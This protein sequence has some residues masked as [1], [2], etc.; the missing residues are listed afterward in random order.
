MTR[1]LQLGS[2]ILVE[3][4]GW[5]RVDQLVAKCFDTVIVKSPEGVRSGLISF[6]FTSDLE[7]QKLNASFRNIDK[8]TNVLAFPAGTDLPGLPAEKPSIIGD[9]ALGYETCFREARERGISL[10]DHVAHLIL[11][12][13]L[14]LFG[15]D[16][17]A[18]EDAEIMEQLEGELLADMGI[19]DP[20]AHMERS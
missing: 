8:P 4:A 16:H 7:V 18:D 5:E 14:H 10:N 19:S 12:G 1:S 6:L 9:I 17:E 3:D 2:E 11:H 15:Y 20:R 13:T